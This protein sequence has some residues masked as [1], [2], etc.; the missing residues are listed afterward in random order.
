MLNKVIEKKI[1]TIKVTLS[2]DANLE[3]FK[4]YILLLNKITKTLYVI[5]ILCSSFILLPLLPFFLY[6]ILPNVNSNIIEPSSEL[7]NQTHYTLSTYEQFSD[8]WRYSFISK[9]I[10]FVGI[11]SII[12]G[13]LGLHT[14]IL[15]FIPIIVPSMIIGL[16][17]IH[18]IIS[19]IDV[20]CQTLIEKNICDIL[21]E[22]NKNTELTC[23]NRISLSRSD[24]Q[25]WIYHEGDFFSNL[26]AKIE[27]I[28]KDDK[29]KPLE[30]EVSKI[31]IQVSEISECIKLQKNNDR[32]T[33]SPT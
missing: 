24:V 21:N 26:Y 6:S 8:N 27:K 1:K 4:K 28:E 10:F 22:L 9:L 7:S 17:V 5:S 13:I 11:C 25:N 31:R 14:T 15:A 23:S 12:I 30:E 29:L 16:G 2:K 3:K 33:P 18:V 19:I 32:T 20:F